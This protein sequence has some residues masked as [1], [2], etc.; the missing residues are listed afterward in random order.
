MS[1]FIELERTGDKGVVVQESGKTKES[2]KNFKRAR[3]LQ[4]HVAS[5]AILAN[6]LGH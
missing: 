3:P 6:L 4:I 1:M 2:H 5:V